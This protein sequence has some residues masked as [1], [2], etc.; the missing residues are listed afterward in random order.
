MN[1]CFE[2]M[3]L[4][5]WI[6]P[7]WTYILVLVCP[8]QKWSP[9]SV[10]NSSQIIQESFIGAFLVH[11]RGPRPIQG[12][13]EGFE[14]ILWPFIGILNSMSLKFFW[15]K[16]SLEYSVLY[17]WNIF[18][19]EYSGFCFELNF[20]LNHFY[21]RFNERMNFLKRSPTPTTDLIHWFH[22]T[23][24]NQLNFVL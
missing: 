1:I 17:W 19:N 5:K 21:A 4:S 10:S 14:S 2:W 12:P 8:R 16:N 15:T 11:F 18:M 7:F 9:K 24:A 20:E 13:M 3:I 22:Q 6:F 23:A